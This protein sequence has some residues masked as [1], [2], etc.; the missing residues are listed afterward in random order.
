M[1]D[2]AQTGLCFP[3][4]SGGKIR[5]RGRTEARLL[6]D[7]RLAA[8][9]LLGKAGLQAWPGVTQGPRSLGP[10]A[11]G[12]NAGVTLVEGQPGI[13]AGAMGTDGNRVLGVGVQRASTPSSAFLDHRGHNRW[14]MSSVT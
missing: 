12:S 11:P 13:S 10:L 5:V 3:R 14:I 8:G 7:L 1:A 2:S 6:P 9:G 4:P